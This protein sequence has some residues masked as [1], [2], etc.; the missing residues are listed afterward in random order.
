MKREFNKAVFDEES[1][2]SPRDIRDVSF[3]ACRFVNC[4]LFPGSDL[5]PQGRPLVNDASFSKC[6]AVACSIGPARLESIQI[7]D[8]KTKQGPLRI[9]GAVAAK[10]TI[11]G[12]CGEF[13]I[14]PTAGFGASSKSLLDANREYYKAIDWAVDISQANFKSIGIRGVPGELIRV[15]G[16][17]QVIVNLAKL[18][19]LA[20]VDNPPYAEIWKSMLRRHGAYGYNFLFAAMRNSG[21]C[22]EI[23]NAL[24]N[25]D[26]IL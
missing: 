13:E 17:N 16:V 15:N 9:L 26:V 5:L 3:T 12:T 14:Y 22:M 4:E 11:S 23:I 19:E 7:N 6:L 20:E 2:L 25:A 10:V 24:R 1:V 18:S 8:L 21:S